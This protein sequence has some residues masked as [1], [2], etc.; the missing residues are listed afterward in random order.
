MGPR[1]AVQ[2]HLD[3]GAPV[4]LAAHFQVFQLGPD[5]FDDSVNVLAEA[6]QERSL[7]PEVFLALKPGQGREWGNP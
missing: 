1:E 7:K 5:G 3:L 4:T 2:A 6:L